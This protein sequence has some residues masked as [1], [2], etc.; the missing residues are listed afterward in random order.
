M[1]DTL[2]LTPSRRLVTRC[3]EKLRAFRAQD[4]GYA[5]VEYGPLTPRDRLVPEDLAV[6]LALNSRASGR[7]FK[8]LMKHAETLN[9]AV[10]PDKPLHETT[11][12]ERETIADLIAEVASW[13]GFSTSLA[14]K[15]LH[16][17]RPRLIP[18]LDNR[19]IF[20]SY[21]D[22]RWPERRTVGQSVRSRSLVLHALECVV[23]DLARPEN[24]GSWTTLEAVDPRLT[25]I[26]V[27]DMVWWMHFREIEPVKPLR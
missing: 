6:T 23:E 24:A 26:E 20:E 14:T 9:L 11:E 17:K 8:S 10:L 5:Y 15:T 16:K 13:P 25:R 3:A 4:D 18:V 7:A 2:I 21:L 12:S 27:L 1:D 19:A 22:S